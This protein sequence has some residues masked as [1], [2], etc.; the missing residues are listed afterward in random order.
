MKKTGSVFFITAA[1]ALVVFAAA[2]QSGE[3][4]RSPVSYHIS[5]DDRSFFE[6]DFIEIAGKKSL[7]D[8]KID[9]PEGRF[10]KGI[11]MSFIPDPPDATNMTG[12]DLD[13]IT[14][15]IFNSGPNNKMGYNQPFIW[16]SGRLNPRLGA[17]SFWAKGDPPFPVPL[18]EQTTIAFGR[19]ERDLLGV[20]IG[21]GNTISAYL[22][23]AR[24]VRHEISSG[25]RWDGSR[26]NH[27]V[28]NWDWTRGL[29]LWLN[30]EKIA[31]SGDG[32]AWFETLPPGLFHLPAPGL[33]Y[34]EVY[35]MDRPLS[36]SEISRLMKSNRPPGDESP[37][38]T[39]KNYDESLIARISGADKNDNLPAVTP[40]ASLSIRE[41]WPEDAAD[42]HVPGWYVIDGRNEMAWPHEYAF[43]TII[44]GDADFHAEK[45][46]IT[47]PANERVNYV[48]V[49]GN[50]TNVKVQ[51]GSP[52]MNDAGDL[53]AV[54]GGDRFF[55]GS[56]ITATEGATFRIPFTEWYGPP[57]D[58]EGDVVHLPQSGEKRV[59]N[60]GLYYAGPRNG[61]PA[62]EEYPITVFEN[63]LDERYTF[64]I[65]A[66]TSRDERRL[67]LASP[68]GKGGKGT[69]DIGAFRRLNIMSA[70]FDSPAGVGAVTLTLPLQ[71]TKK[72]ETL[73]VRVHDP[74][75][76]SRLWNQF[77]VRLDGFDGKN[78]TLSLTIDFHDLVLTSG[79]R[80]WIDIGTAGKCEVRIGDRKR[81]SMLH[82]VTMP[83]FMAVD[84]YADKE[85]LSSKAQYSKMYEF[86]PW[87][88]T[89]REVSLDNP[90]CYGGPFDVLMPALA[91]HRVNPDHF[92][93]NF[94]IL[95]S[96][97]DYDDGH[98]IH[99]DQHDLVTITDPM[100]RLPGRR[101]CTI[102]TSSAT[103][104][105][106][107][108]HNARIPTA[109][110]AAAG[111]MTHSS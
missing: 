58:F 100:E 94:M 39:R 98:P 21:E 43:F 15:V 34:D 73:F 51:A 76:P 46:D 32:E 45:V 4:R 50:L 49:S 96:G 37:V 102:S 107:G 28:L 48:T 105:R 40:G 65:H 64:A 33:V 110:W 106:T 63:G 81:P 19:K 38:F 18:F 87:Q 95:M 25:I 93:A 59:H 80:L 66:L 44:P 90:Y 60:V 17:V 30:G 12:I 104:L 16:G 61:E 56:M 57:E 97:P 9:F 11:R 89:G 83:V 84:K 24:Y 103:P 111:T 42:G 36:K 78:A 79:D 74:A 101:T 62:G 3:L 92:I 22:R 13:L 67:A 41:V 72:S 82:V 86:L 88:F 10:G 77:A 53:F 5:F 109:R 85:M 52:D 8:R 47:T 71:T 68:A 91:V 27:V 26:W 6:Q 54:P 2:A 23:D 29:E 20:V 31:E 70:P 99:P 7:E 55:Y 14:A 35:L 69:Y 108:G 1:A 75:V